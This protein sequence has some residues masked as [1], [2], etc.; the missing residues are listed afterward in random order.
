MEWPT[1]LNEPE[2]SW[3][4]SDVAV[5]CPT[6]ECIMEAR[7]KQVSD[8]VENTQVTVTVTNDAVNLGKILMQGVQ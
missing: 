5:D 7:K 3:P 4:S 6:E 8:P 2:G 1:W